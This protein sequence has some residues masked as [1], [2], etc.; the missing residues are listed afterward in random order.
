MRF[1]GECGEVEFANFV[2]IGTVLFATKFCR[3][4][5]AVLESILDVAGIQ[6]VQ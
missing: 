6:Q 2:G 4:A 5:L 3:A 1:S